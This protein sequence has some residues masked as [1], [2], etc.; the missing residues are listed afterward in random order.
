MDQVELRADGLLLR[1][2]RT[3]DAEGVYQAC[4]D[5][6]IQRWTTVPSPYPR[7]TAEWFVGSCGEL[8]AAANPTFACVD[9]ASGELLGSFDL[10]ECASEEGPLIGY[11]VAPQARRRGVARDA[12]RRLAQWAF[13]DLGFGRVRWA[14]YVGNTASRRVAES[15]GFV[16]EG[17]ARKGLVHR[18]ERVDA[19]VGSM[20]PEDLARTEPGRSVRP[21]RLEGWPTQPVELR[22]KRLLLRA[23]R[24]DDA[25]ALLAYARDPVARMWD[26]EDAPDLAAAVAR[27]RRRMDWSAG[28]GAVWT[29]A[30]PDDTHV[31]GGIQLFDLEAKSRSAI[32]GY[33]LMPEARGNGYAA[34]ALRTITQW[35]ITETELHRIGL[36]HAVGNVASCSV[37][38][39]AGYAL[40][41][42]MRQSYP[43]GNGVLQDNHLHAHLRTDPTPDATPG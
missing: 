5:E 31:W 3:E 38:L 43:S 4:Q 17:T 11:W 35:A 36:M 25:P 30:D 18:G 8:W 19:W 10:Q 42:T 29:I 24:E 15:A 41:G 1:P 22:S 39:A 16:F 27:A 40:E 21:K 32:T 7:T 6:Q 33:G 23:T 28:D 14:A 34:E 12:T 9:G 26:P 2:F 20:L 37:A 13:D